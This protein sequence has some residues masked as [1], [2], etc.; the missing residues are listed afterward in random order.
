M[1]DSVSESPE[2]DSVPADLRELRTTS[3][4]FRAL[5]ERGDGADAARFDAALWAQCGVDGAVLVTDLTGFT[6][7]TRC[8]GIVHFLAMFRRFALACAPL[9]GANGGTLL[10]QEAD[11]LIGVFSDAVNALSAALAMQD[12]V[13]ALNRGRA[14]DD[15]VGLCIGIEQGMFLRFD[16]DAFGDA[17]NVAFKLGEDLAARDEILIGAEAYRHVLRAGFDLAGYSVDGP[18]RATTGGVELE[19]WSIRIQRLTPSGE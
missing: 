14:S 7:I 18:R 9:I 17:V 10:K 4:L 5:D 3:Q 16:D 8:S 15:Q 6:K 11:D 1:L 2:T 13:A 19:H 12:A